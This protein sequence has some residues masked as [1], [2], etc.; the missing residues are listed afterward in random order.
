MHVLILQIYII[1]IGV[2][3]LIS[4]QISSS[5][6]DW[7]SGSLSSEQLSLEL[8]QVEREI[9]KRT[10]ERAMVSD[11][12]VNYSQLIYSVTCE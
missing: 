10:Q 5:R 11:T 7:S 6:A 1:V 3:I 4:L 12:R 2:V 9:G 8:H